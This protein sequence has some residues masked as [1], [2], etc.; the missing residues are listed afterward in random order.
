MVP[1]DWDDVREIYEAGIAT[2]NATFE[3]SAPEWAD[4]DASHLADHRVVVVID[5]VVVAWAALSPVSDRCV[6]GGVAENSVYV[7]PGHRG[8]GIGRLV[9]AEL[10]DR[11]E[12]A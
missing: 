9:L 5:G 10:I 12:A 2:G 3:A 8:Q 11:A 7:H 6:Y 1:E 4:W